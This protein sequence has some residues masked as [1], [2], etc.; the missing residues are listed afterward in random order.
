MDAIQYIETGADGV[1]HEKNLHAIRKS[2][3]QL[4][5]VSKFITAIL[6]AKLVDLGKL[7]LDTDINKYLRSWKCPRVTTL[8]RLLLHESGVNTQSWYPGNKTVS[9]LKGIKNIDI[10]EGNPVVS[11]GPVTFGKSRKFFYTGT[12]YQIIQQVLEDKFRSSFD[13][14][15]KRYVFSILGMKNTHAKLLSVERAYMQ[16]ASAGI[17]STASDLE[18]LLT[19]LIDSFHDRGKLLSK[20]T[21]QIFAR[22]VHTVDRD[23]KNGLGMYVSSSGRI[24]HRGWNYGYRSYVEM[25]PRRNTYKILLIKYREDGKDPT[26]KAM[27]RLA[28]LRDR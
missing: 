5:S 15:L 27:R 23:E 3:F 13:D 14:L 17:W 12:G 24:F 20:E 18:K 2:Q 25:N 11:D 19:D 8:R 6:V 21:L 26:K 1:R 9:E 28:R 22:G 4:A 7:D 16:F 10:L